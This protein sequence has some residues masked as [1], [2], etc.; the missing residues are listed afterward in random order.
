MIFSLRDV[1]LSD[2]S[3]LNFQQPTNY[4]SRFP[5]PSTS[6]WKF[7]VLVNFDF[8]YKS[9]ALSNLGGSHLPCDF[10]FLTDLGKLV[11]F[12]SLVSFKFFMVERQLPR[13]L[14][15]VSVLCLLS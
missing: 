8:L 11:G 15:E 2:L 10:I 14:H 9:V 3:T 1:N 5:F 6:P 4:T 12:F 13:F 7:S